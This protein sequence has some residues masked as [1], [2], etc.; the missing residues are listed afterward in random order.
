MSEKGSKEGKNR[1][2][3]LSM[4]KQKKGKNQMEIQEKPKKILVT[5]E[6]SILCAI[7]IL[8][9]NKNWGVSDTC[10]TLISVNE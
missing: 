3:F 7:I 5:Q 2:R 10:F 6:V 4:E 1:V 9:E 8:T